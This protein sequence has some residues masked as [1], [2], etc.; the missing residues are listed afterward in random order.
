MLNPYFL[1]LPEKEKN[2]EVEAANRPKPLKAWL[3]NLPMDNEH[4]LPKLVYERINEINRTEIGARQLTSILESF[5]P[6]YSTIHRLLT[7]HIFVDGFPISPSKQKT[8]DMLIAI[9]KE[10]AISYYF[11]LKAHETQMIPWIPTKIRPN[12]VLRLIHTY[13]DLLVLHYLLYID[14]PKWIWLDINSIYRFALQHEIG[15]VQI[16]DPLLTLKKKTTIQ[17]TYNRILLLRITD[18]YGLTQTEIV[19]LNT[20]TERW[21]DLVVLNPEPSG[22]RTLSKGWVIDL[23]QDAAPFWLDKPDTVDASKNCLQMDVQP[24]LRLF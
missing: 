22:D 7:S 5:L 8:A 13:T 16:A 11:L 2:P 4:T 14:D 9:T 1:S 20:I 19:Y 15:A 17:E 3:M 10:S 6:V 23:D 12:Q 21:D 24:L 18:P